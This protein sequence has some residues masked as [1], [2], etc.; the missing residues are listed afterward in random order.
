M[1]FFLRTYYLLQSVSTSNILLKLTGFFVG[2]DRLI[3]RFN[4]KNNSRAGKGFRMRQDSIFFNG[5]LLTHT[6]PR[7]N[8]M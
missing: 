5:R 7:K 6:K 2:E 3:M 1:Q 8:Y 4:M